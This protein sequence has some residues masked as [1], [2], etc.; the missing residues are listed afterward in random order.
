L[1]DNLSDQFA[2]DR[3]FV[4]MYWRSH[5]RA[6]QLAKVP[7]DLPAAWTTWMLHRQLRQVVTLPK[8]VRR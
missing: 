7:N 4:R 6:G 2:V 3:I 8:L 1:I 5:P